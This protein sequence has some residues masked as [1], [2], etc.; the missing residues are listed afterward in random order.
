[1]FKIHRS[2]ELTPGVKN[3]SIAVYHNE[4][5]IGVLYHKT[6]VF[7]AT[8]LKNGSYKIT[9]R[10]GGW[11]TIS[12][13][14]VMTTALERIPGF[15]NARVSRKKGELIYSDGRL[16]IPFPSEELVVQS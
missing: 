12:T 2:F 14:I 3:N 5:S 15:Q 1:M 4:G 10:S 6:Q 16:S 8:R 13:A 11:P 7:H 9:L